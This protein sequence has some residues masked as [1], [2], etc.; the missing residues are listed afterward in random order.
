[1]HEVMIR[2]RLVQSGKII[3]C[4]LDDRLDLKE[5]L[6]IL[7]DLTGEDISGSLVYDPIKKIFLDRNIPLSSFN[8]DY[9]MMLYLFS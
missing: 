3:E 8:M 7:S 5:N 6:A 4:L 9:F 1:M 2:F